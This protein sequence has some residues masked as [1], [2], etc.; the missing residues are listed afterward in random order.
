MRVSWLMAGCILQN[1]TIKPTV[2]DY[3]RLIESTSACLQHIPEHLDHLHATSAPSFYVSCYVIGDMK[4]PGFRWRSTSLKVSCKN[5]VRQQDVHSTSLSKDC[6]G[7]LQHFQCLH[8]P[9]SE[10]II[11]TT[12]KV[13]TNRTA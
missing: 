13:Y 9:S 11:S 5:R 2:C 4:R 12:R 6:A 7:A 1:A 3:E 8:Y 10:V